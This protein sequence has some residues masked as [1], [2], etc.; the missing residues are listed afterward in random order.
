MADVAINGLPAASGLTSDD[1]LEIENDPSGTAASQK[2][3]AAQLLSYVEGAATAFDAA[4]AAAAA[5]AAAIAASQPVDSDLTAI[6]ALATTSFGRAFL[7]FADEAAFKSA[8]NLEIG[9]D[10][11]QHDADLDAIAALTTTAFGRGLL[12]HAD[13]AAFKAAVNLDAGVDFEAVDADIVRADTGDTLTA[14]YLSDS[15]A[16]GTISSGTVTPAP[17]TDEENFQH[18]T[19]NGAHTL[20]PPASPCSVVVEITNGASA[21]AITTSGFTQVTGDAFTTTNGDDFHCYITRTQNFS[22][23]HVVALQ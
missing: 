2:L 12:E 11:Q 16:R 7:G 9:V 5:Q 14:G 8:V 18:Y 1:L 20:A 15:Y 23:L 13:E 10:V 22:H 19:N 4:G 21:G 3:T 17:A 6:A